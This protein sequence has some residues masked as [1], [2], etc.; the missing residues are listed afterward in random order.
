M[1]KTIFAICVLACLPALAGCS[2]LYDPCDDLETKLCADLGGDCAVLSSNASVHDAIIPARRRQSEKAQCEMYAADQNYLSYTLPWTRYLI[3]QTRDP[4]TPA[5]TL[6][7]PVAVDGIAS[8]L[9]GYWL[10]LLPVFI[11]P[12]ML[13]F[14]FRSM[15]AAKKAAQGGGQPPPGQQ[16]PNT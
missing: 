10:Y 14:S 13:L 2:M 5:P 16:P 7:P 12:L 9:S 15:R 8:G 3:E 11:I 6:T 4:A 1:P